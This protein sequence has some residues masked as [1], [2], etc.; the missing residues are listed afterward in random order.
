MGRIRDLIN[1][2]INPVEPEKSLDELAGEAG[3][4]ATDLELLKKSANGVEGKWQFADDVEET[5]KKKRTEIELSK[6]TQIQPELKSIE[7]DQNVDYE[8][9]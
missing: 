8:R 4:D 1:I 7:T 5:K 9:D 3:I 6:D 2:F